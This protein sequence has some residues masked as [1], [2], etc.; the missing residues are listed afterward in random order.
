VTLPAF[1]A[2]VYGLYVVK[3]D[4]KSK[5]APIVVSPDVTIESAVDG[6]NV[7]IYGSGFGDRPT[8]PYDTMVS[9]TILHQTKKKT[10][11]LPTDIV[12][13]SDTEIVVNCPDASSGDQVTVNA[14]FGSARSQV[15]TRNT[16][17]NKHQSLQRS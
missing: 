8:A 17:E 15:R 11:E 14:L 5:L 10:I 2:G 6:D 1:D 7:V 13:W 3:A 9:V 4:M 12:S 16:Y